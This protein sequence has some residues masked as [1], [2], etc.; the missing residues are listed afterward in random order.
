V[1]EV[2]C[3]FVSFGYCFEVGIEVSFVL[4]ALGERRNNIVSLDDIELF[5]HIM[6]VGMRLKVFE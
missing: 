1:S 4:S 2:A 5:A 6:K 3:D